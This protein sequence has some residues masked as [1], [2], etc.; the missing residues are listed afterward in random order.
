MAARGRGG[1]QTARGMGAG[2]RGLNTAAASPPGPWA[3][4]G[5]WVTER[6]A[7]SVFLLTRTG[8]KFLVPL[9]VI[10]SM[11]PVVTYSH[12]LHPP[13]ALG[14]WLWALTLGGALG[15][16]MSSEGGALCYRGVWAPRSV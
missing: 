2:L 10:V 7:G 15:S 9:R 11:V 8:C 13:S 3:G 16:P 6:E 4:A 14:D 5:V 12:P 1:S